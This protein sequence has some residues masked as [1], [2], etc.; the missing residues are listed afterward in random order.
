MFVMRRPSNVE[1]ERF[2]DR[3]HDLPLSYG[4][5]GIVRRPSDV[6]RLDEHVVAI[7]HGEADFERARIALVQWQHFDVGWVEVFPRKAAIEAGTDV[8]VLIRHFGFWSLNGARVLYHVVGNDTQASFGFAY[9]TLTNHAESGEELFEVLIDPVS[10]DVSYRI[11]A[12]SWPQHA[13]T[14]IGQ[15][16]VRLLQERFRCDS[17]AAM[18]RATLNPEPR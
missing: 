4:P 10:G 18:K 8:A 14:R 6:D 13:L 3:S 11:R 1:I 5:T 12:M 15:P 2:L 7:G 9:G 16:I 17:A